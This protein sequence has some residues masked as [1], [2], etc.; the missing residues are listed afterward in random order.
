MTKFVYFAYY[1]LHWGITKKQRVA[2]QNLKTVWDICW[3]ARKT[4]KTACVY[5]LFLGSHLK[6]EKEKTIFSVKLFFLSGLYHVFRIFCVF[7]SNTK[8]L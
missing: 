6:Y 4:L 5:D 1:R 2:L 7:F 8:I 3:E